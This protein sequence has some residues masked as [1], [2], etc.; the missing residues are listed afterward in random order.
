[1]LASGG[2]SIICQSL[3]CTTGSDFC[4]LGNKKVSEHTT[5]DQTTEYP[6]WA[7]DGPPTKTQI[8]TIR[9]QPLEEKDAFF[10]FFFFF[11][12]RSECSRCEEN[13]CGGLS[14]GPRGQS[15]CEPEGEVQAGQK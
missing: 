15:G 10:F 6:M 2:Q 5:Y 9:F 7:M 4:F 13:M 12:F 1:M 14:G 11:F 3:F 8:N